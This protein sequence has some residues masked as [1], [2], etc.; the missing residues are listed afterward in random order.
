MHIQFYSNQAWCDYVFD[1]TYNRMNF[2][3]Q[4][5]FYRENKHL[6]G[7]GSA[8]AFGFGLLEIQTGLESCHNVGDG[9]GL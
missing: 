3:E 4:E 6:K 7:I 9:D 5:R 2:D 8:K 1:D